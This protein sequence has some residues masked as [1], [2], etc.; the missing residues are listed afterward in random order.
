MTDPRIVSALREATG[1]QL[2]EDAQFI[3]DMAEELD[4]YITNGGPV[5]FPPVAYR[6]AALALAVAECIDLGANS[7]IHRRASTPNID[8]HFDAYFSFGGNGEP[9]TFPA[10]LAALLEGGR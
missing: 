2:R 5:K 1:E 7:G 3:V 10:A 8:A 9:D 4:T 6:L